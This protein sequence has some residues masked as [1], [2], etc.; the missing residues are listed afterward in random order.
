MFTPSPTAREGQLPS[1]LQASL[2]DAIRKRMRGTAKRWKEKA[3]SNADLEYPFIRVNEMSSP[4][5]SPACGGSAPACGWPPRREP[6]KR[7][8]LF[9]S[10]RRSPASLRDAI[11]KR[12]R[13][14]ALRGRDGRR[15]R[16]QMLYSNI[17]LF[18]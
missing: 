13:W 10:P 17:R 8:N 15:K 9:F 14:R 12:M 3:R 6:M 18:E 11:R 16:G 1:A 4:A 7:G 2:R 5:P